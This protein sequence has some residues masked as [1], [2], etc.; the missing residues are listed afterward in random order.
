MGSRNE[1]MNDGVREKELSLTR[2]Q[3]RGNFIPTKLFFSVLGNSTNIAPALGLKVPFNTYDLSTPISVSF[4]EP[5]QYQAE[6]STGGRLI[7]VLS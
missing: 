4:W 5:V 2:Q 7:I 1:V 3:G 6:S